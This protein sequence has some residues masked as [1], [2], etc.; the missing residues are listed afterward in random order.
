M[1]EEITLDEVKKTYES[2]MEE[3]CTDE[4]AQETLKNYI[5]HCE[6]WNSIDTSKYGFG[7]MLKKEEEKLS[8]SRYLKEKKHMQ[9]QKKQME[10]ERVKMMAMKPIDRLFY[11]EMNDKV[12]DLLRP[13]LD[14]DEGK[15]LMED[16]SLWSEEGNA[17]PY[18]KIIFTAISKAYPK[19]FPEFLIDDCINECGSNMS[20]WFKCIYG[21]GERIIRTI[22][23][24]CKCFYEFGQEKNDA[25]K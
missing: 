24:C 19:D 9:E 3:T 22:Y 11:R 21:D 4:Q 18:I 14:T 16:I 15:K 6:I 17:T 8:V 13:F 1:S 12:G 5:R 7:G 2:I 23:R 10:E 20:P 25:T